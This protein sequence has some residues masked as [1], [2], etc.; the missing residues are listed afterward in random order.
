MAVN[1]GPLVNYGLTGRVKR[2]PGRF[3]RNKIDPERS[4]GY[5]YSPHSREEVVK[6][7][8]NSRKVISFFFV[9][10]SGGNNGMLSFVFILNLSV[11]DFE[12]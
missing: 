1:R 8:L 10:L 7:S 12:I 4:L 2:I 9:E 11:L 3:S 5:V 6:V